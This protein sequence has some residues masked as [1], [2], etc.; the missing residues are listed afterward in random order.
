MS[1]SYA[2]SEIGNTRARRHRPSTAASS[3]LRS[4][5]GAGLPPWLSFSARWP[6]VSTPGT[7]TGVVNG[8]SPARVVDR[9]PHDHD[10]HRLVPRRVLRVVRRG[11]SRACRPSSPRPSSRPVW[12]TSRRPT[13]PG[14]RA[15]SRSTPTRR[16]ARCSVCPA[17]RGPASGSRPARVSQRSSCRPPGCTW[18]AVASSVPS[19]GGGPLVLLHA[20]R[21][22]VRSRRR[23]RCTRRSCPNPATRRTPGRVL[24]F[25]TSIQ[26]GVAGLIV[27][28]VGRR[29]GNEVD[30][31]GDP[32]LVRLR[33][34]VV[35]HVVEQP[36]VARRVLVAVARRQH[37][38]RLLFARGEEPLGQARDRSR[39]CA[40]TFSQTPWCKWMTSTG[41]VV[42]S[43]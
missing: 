43:A 5:G 7:S 10:P 34:R 31:V 29:R 13:R 2:K 39:P 19:Y 18:P 36:V 22:R 28:A 30:V 26:I 38:A 21:V 33:E 3:G 8:S 41:G 15:R 42:P 14:P 17:C 37:E 11:R 27:F 32:H 23:D 25:C 24:P 1:P 35:Q 16:G 20:L 4:A 40:T 9:H 6:C 12:P